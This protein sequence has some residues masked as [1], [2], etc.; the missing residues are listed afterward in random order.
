MNTTTLSNDFATSH[1]V[2]QAYQKLNST[3]VGRIPSSCQEDAGRLLTST[4]TIPCPARGVCDSHTP[5]DAYFV[6][7]Q[8][9]EH[10]KMLQCSHA[11]CRGSGRHFRYCKVCDQVTAK[12]NFNKR[13]EHLIVPGSPTSPAEMMISNAAITSKKRRRLLHVGS[14]GDSRT[15]SRSCIIAN[16]PGVGDE[17]QESTHEGDASTRTTTCMLVPSC[18][19]EDS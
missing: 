17:Q 6:I 18:D 9:C 7:S 14:D 5:R 13:H 15:N 3:T 16:A 4:R 12:R 8:D 1:N 19:S 10:G 11:R 2:D